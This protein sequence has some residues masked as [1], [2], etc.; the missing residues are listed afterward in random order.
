MR[1][2]LKKATDDIYQFGSG[3]Y[4]LLLIFLFFLFVFR[5][6]EHNDIY[7]GLWKIFFT[8]ALLLA[9]FNV[10]HRKSVKIAVS[11][12]AIPAVLF[13]WISIF[14][15]S[16]LIIVAVSLSNTLLMAVCTGSILCDVVLRAQVTLETLKGVISAYFLVA[17]IFAYI[18]L[19][20]E[21]ATPGSILI[22]NQV[23][24]P[25]ENPHHF[26]SLML[27]YSFT[28]LLTIGYGDI[29]AMKDVSQ[30]ACVI[31]GLI[32]QFY[33][34]ILVARLVA[35]YSF[36]SEKN[37]CSLREQPGKSTKAHEA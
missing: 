15:H 36:F 21:A 37:N 13:T 17:F 1:Q 33:I 26:F 29:V 14:N 8:A 7:I 28:T 9:I 5:P 25:F 3:H 19:L 20:I 35:V 30:T 6:Y 34:A 2:V 23:L 32:G 18:Y 16:E 11:I 4:N 27:Y 12:L 10:H 24:N 22:Q 31:E